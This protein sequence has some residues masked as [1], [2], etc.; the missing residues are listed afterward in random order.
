[1]NYLQ[2]AGLNETEAKCYEALLELTDTKP[3]ELAKL[4]NETRTNCYK[5]LDTLTA[6]GLAERFEKGKLW[7]YRATNPVRL[8]E[9]AR[10][11]RAEQEQ[12]EQ[13]LELRVQKLS[14]NYLTA[15]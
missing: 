6:L 7:H 4:V 5:I 9:L 1:M 2:A 11:R 8:L 13:E 15:H 12:S 10:K 3:A 14:R